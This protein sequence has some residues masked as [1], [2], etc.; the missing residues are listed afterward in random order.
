MF[1]WI[2][3][4]R[5]GHNRQYTPAPDAF[6]KLPGSLG[7]LY[8]Y[9]HLPIMLYIICHIYMTKR[10]MYM[11]II[12][13]DWYSKRKQWIFGWIVWFLEESEEVH[14]SVVC[15]KI[16][17]EVMSSF[18]DWFKTAPGGK[19]PHDYGKSHC[20]R[21]KSTTNGPCSI[22]KLNYQRVSYHQRSW[23]IPPIHGDLGDGLWH[24]SPKK[25]TK[26]NISRIWCVNPAHADGDLPF[27]NQ[28]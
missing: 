28:P 1:H 19:H 11:S 2:P 23:C 21:G 4:A 15:P 25:E 17:Q 18:W 24:C 3:P 14:V 6:Y 27:P 16:F 26:Q 12:L 9:T 13:K 22:A 5:L 20:V 7:D 10:M 8:M